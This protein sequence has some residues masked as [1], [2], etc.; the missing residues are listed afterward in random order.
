MLLL[1]DAADLTLALD[2]GDTVTVTVPMQLLPLDEL[3]CGCAEV[4]GLATELCT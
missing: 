3:G 4:T 1:N 2:P